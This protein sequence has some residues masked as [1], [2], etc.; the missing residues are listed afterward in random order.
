M[1]ASTARGSRY[2]RG[3]P[4]R[5]REAFRLIGTLDDLEGEVCDLLPCALQLW[6]G[7]TT[8]SEEMSQRR[9]HLN[10]FETVD[11]LSRS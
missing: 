1:R 7:K 4:V 6:S 8:V 5:Y 9:Q 3:D 11:S 10:R 2:V